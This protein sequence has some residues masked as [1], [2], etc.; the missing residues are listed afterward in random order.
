MGQVIKDGRKTL[1]N[2]SEL[3]SAVKISSAVLELGAYLLSSSHDQVRIEHHLLD[4][5]I[6]QREFS[7]DIAVKKKQF[8]NFPMLR[9]DVKFK[10]HS[11]KRCNLLS[12]HTKST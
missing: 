3:M 2:F 8:Q 5:I 12:T 10:V 11:T 1:E 7:E 9:R 4:T 6:K